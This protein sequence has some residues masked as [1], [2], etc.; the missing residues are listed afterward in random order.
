[1]PGIF[2]GVKVGWCIRLTTSHPSVSWLSRKRGNLYIS[3]PNGLPPPVAGIA[4]LLLNLI[5]I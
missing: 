2:L 1:V 5:L 4:F 3:Q